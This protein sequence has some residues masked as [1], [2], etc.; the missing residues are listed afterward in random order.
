MNGVGELEPTPSRFITV[1]DIQMS[2]NRIESILDKPEAE[3]DKELLGIV[4][5]TAQC[6]VG[7]FGVSASPHGNEQ[8]NLSGSGTLVYCKGSYFILTARHVW[9][10]VS[11]HSSKLGITLM[12]NVGHRF[13]MEIDTISPFGPPAPY[14]LGELGPD[15]VM[16]RIP[17][18]HVNAIKAYG[19]AFYDLD[20]IVSPVSNPEYFEMRMLIGIP[21]CLGKFSDNYAIIQIRGWHA[22]IK[23]P[24]T[25]G[26]FDYCDTL[27]NVSDLP[28]EKSVG[29]VSGGGLWSVSMFDSPSGESVQS[30][31]I[32]EGV[33]FWQFPL[34]GETRIV[35]CH[36]IDTVKEVAR[37]VGSNGL[38]T[39]V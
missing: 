29:G 37:I 35:R 1:G 28:T 39:H 9:D 32:L 15:I 18:I 24:Q 36:G 21:A 5:N 26:E 25:I 31:A 22:G 3:S 11:K 17:D 10:H 33:A 7:I 27:V 6:A 2:L 30:I 12:T 8:L 16:L 38:A 4:S 14:K 19:R 13:W 20:A 34:E 23:D